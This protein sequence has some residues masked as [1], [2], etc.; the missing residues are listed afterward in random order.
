MIKDQLTDP[1]PVEHGCSFESHLKKLFPSASPSYF[2]A[3]V[4]SS[5]GTYNIFIQLGVTT[6]IGGQYG[7]EGCN[8]IREK[9]TYENETKDK[10]CKVKVSFCNKYLKPN[11]E[12][13]RVGKYKFDNQDSGTVKVEV[14]YEGK[15]YVS[16]LAA[17]D[18]SKGEF[19]EVTEYNSTSTAWQNRVIAYRF[20]AR[21]KAYDGTE[22]AL[23]N[24][25][26]RSGTIGE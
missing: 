10:K 17:N 9:W 12:F 18:F 6:D 15:T 5:K 24:V 13:M 25:V 21:L 7:R 14:W 26:H 23:H 19:L 20:N 16:G 4:E 22:L 2:I 3:D 11:L 8:T 1:Q